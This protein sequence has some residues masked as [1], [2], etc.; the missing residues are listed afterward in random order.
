MP[1]RSSP[2]GKSPQFWLTCSKARRSP[3]TRMNLVILRLACCCGLRLSEISGLRLGDVRVGVDRPHLVIRPTIAKCGRGRVVPLLWD[4]G[5][6]DDIAAWVATRRAPGRP[7]PGPG[8]LFT[9]AAR[10]RKA[11]GSA[12]AAKTLPDRVSAP[13]C[14]AAAQPHYSP[15]APYLHQP[16]LGWAPHAGRSPRR[17]RAQQHQRHV[18]LPAPGGGE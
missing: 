15:R 14:G 7:G 10:W 11:A 8:D 6:L 16:C 12:C 1:P 9:T 5:T 3:N 13:W 18:V 2:V 17:D 4:Q